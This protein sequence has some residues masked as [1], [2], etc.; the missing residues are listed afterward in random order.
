M[1][2]VGEE[3]VWRE[4]SDVVGGARFRWLLWEGVGA[5]SV[6]VSGRMSNPIQ[7]VGV[8]WWGVVVG[9][10][11]SEGGVVIGVEREHCLRSGEGG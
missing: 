1:V 11:E 3:C 4:L 8:S 6:G 7:C 2:G 10:V 9:E 5:G